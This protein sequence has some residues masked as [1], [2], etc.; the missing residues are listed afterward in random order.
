M[1]AVL[2]GGASHY[3]QSMSTVLSL[4]LSRGVFSHSF[5][6]IRSTGVEF[7][8]NDYIKPL[9]VQLC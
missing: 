3:A 4:D 9:A 6:E 7:L 5:L 8:G 2:V 1:S